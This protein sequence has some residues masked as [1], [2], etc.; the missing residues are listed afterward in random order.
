MCIDDE[1][2]I[3]DVA[4]I[5]L[6]TVGGYTV[7]TCKSGKEGIEKIVSVKPD[8]ILL[9]VMM[10]GLDGP[11]TFRQINQIDELGH[12]P[13]IF[14]TAKVQPKEVTLYTDMGALGVI[15]KP[16]DPMKLAHEVQGHWQKHQNRTA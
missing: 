12:V 15:T 5:A 14:M 4:Q 6:E 13:I 2:D 8:L 10:P 7:S 9:D 1:I 11:A 3:L 16:F